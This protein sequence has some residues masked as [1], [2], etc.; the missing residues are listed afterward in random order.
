MIIAVTN[1]AIGVIKSILQRCRGFS[2]EKAT[3]SVFVA[4]LMKV[5]SLWL[6]KRLSRLREVYRKPMKA[7]ILGEWF[8]Y[9]HYK[10]DHRTRSFPKRV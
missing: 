3:D 6:G 2:E 7:P 5:S 10:I 1:V 8:E 9:L 4:D